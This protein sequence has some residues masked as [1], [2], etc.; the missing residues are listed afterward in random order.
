MT[1]RLRLAFRIAWCAK[2]SCRRACPEFSSLAVLFG[3]EFDLLAYFLG[4]KEALLRHLAVCGHRE[5]WGV[6]T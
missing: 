5:G 2:P 1:R 4:R 6:C 3:S